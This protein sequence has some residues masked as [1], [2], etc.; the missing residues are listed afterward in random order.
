MRLYEIAAQ[1]AE[2]ERLITDD[3]TLAESLSDTLQALEDAFEAK[4]ENV[5]KLIRNTEADIEALK[6]E[7]KRLSDRRKRLEAKRDRLKDYL[8]EQLNA[9]GIE[10]V[11]TPLFTA[12]LQRNSQPSLKIVNEQEIPQVFWIPQPPVLDRKGIIEYA[13]TA[14]AVPGVELV[15]GKH[16]RI[17]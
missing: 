8:T 4:A 10:K 11:K 3:E 7:E 17:R 14:D 2:L 13:K 9:S 5:V 1:Y 15:Y 12:S 6:T 16:L